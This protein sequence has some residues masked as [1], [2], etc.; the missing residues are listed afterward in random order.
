MRSYLQV[1]LVLVLLVVA[2]GLVLS[3]LEVARDA[4]ARVTCSNNL[5]QVALAL[6]NYESSYGSFPAG[7]VPHP[8]LPPDRRLSWMPDIMPYM[9][10]LGGQL[11]LDPNEPW[12]A[13]TNNPPRFRTSDKDEAK[14]GDENGRVVPFGPYKPFWC[15]AN[16]E[17]ERQGTPPLTHYLGVAGVGKDPARLPGDDPAAGAFGYDRRTKKSDVKDGLS[18][19]LLLAETVRDNG[20]WTAGGYPTLRGPDPR[21]QP[22][23][24]LAAQFGSRHSGGKVNVALMDGSVRPLDPKMSPR[25][26]EALATIHGDDAELLPADW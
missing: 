14:E 25:A 17:H 21:S 10:C 24:G 9:E 7:T 13:E 18:T 26:F 5:K 23:L 22:H 1:L 20:P 6:H 11:L 15:P 8:T 2:L 16:P 3:G 4:A 12:D 19:T